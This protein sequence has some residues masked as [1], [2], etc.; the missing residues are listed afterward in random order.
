MPES[1]ESA[2]QQMAG[3]FAD[4]SREEQLQL[5]AG[6]ERAGAAVYRSLAENEDDTATRE[7]LLLAAS[8]EE[9]NASFLEKGR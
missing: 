6:L 4:R 3:L 1:I 5:L 2:M 8:R 9:E 7:G